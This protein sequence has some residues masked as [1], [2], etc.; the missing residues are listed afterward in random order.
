[1]V[2]SRKVNKLPAQL[3]F[4]IADKT[5]DFCQHHGLSVFDVITD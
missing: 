1:M 5:P 3:L 2:V 4:Y